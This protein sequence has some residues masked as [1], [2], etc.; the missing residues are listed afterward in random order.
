VFVLG[1][2]FQ[3]SLIFAIKIGAYPSE[4]PDRLVTGLTLKHSARMDSLAKDKHIS[5]FP[6]FVNDGRN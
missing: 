4:A 6:T 1:K 3:R 5:L 2:P